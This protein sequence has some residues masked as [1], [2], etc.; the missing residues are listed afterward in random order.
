MRSHCEILLRTLKL[1]M[2]FSSPNFRVWPGVCL[3]GRPQR[4]LCILWHHASPAATEKSCDPVKRRCPSSTAEGPQAWPPPRP[5]SCQ[6][7]DG[8]WI[9]GAN[10]GEGRHQVCTDVSS[11]GELLL[12]RVLK[13][14]GEFFC[15]PFYL[16]RFGEYR[17]HWLST[18]H[19]VPVSGRQNQVPGEQFHLFCYSSRH[20][21]D[22]WQ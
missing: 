13:V 2:L 10:S 15:G 16:P 22:L 9:H 14:P 19:E 11:R 17:Q 6:Q 3:W 5:E 4:G 20:F 12:S 21:C 1:L 8:S 7:L 18:R